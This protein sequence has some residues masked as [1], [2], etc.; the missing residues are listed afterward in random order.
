ME[1]VRHSRVDLSPLLTH[2]F[3]LENIHEAYDLFGERRDG[4]MKV[5]IKI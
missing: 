2:T 3:T 1:M 5:A 4:V